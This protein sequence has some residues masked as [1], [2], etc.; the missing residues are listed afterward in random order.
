[1]YTTTLIFV[2]LAYLAHAKWK[3]SLAAAQY[4]ESSKNHLAKLL[5]M[6][7]RPGLARSGLLHSPTQPTSPLVRKTEPKM[8]ED[9]AFSFELPGKGIK[10]FGTVNMKFKPLLDSDSEVV[11]ARGDLPLEL[12]AEEKAGRVVVTKEGKMG[13]QAGDILRFSLI[14]QGGRPGQRQPA[15]F[16][17]QKCMDE[18]GFD[19]FVE[20]LMTNTGD[21]ADEVVMVFERPKKDEF[22]VGI[23]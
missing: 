12:R 22:S 6:Q 18:Q 4:Q 10:E 17:V 20:A 2:C 9:F 16:D 13:E 19:V 23:L 15:M 3:S 8:R 11:V 5:L 7:V 21:D 1:M 14:W